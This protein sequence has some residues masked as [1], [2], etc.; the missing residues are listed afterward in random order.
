MC[1]AGSIGTEVIDGDGP[2]PP[3]KI[4]TG[5]WSVALASTTSIWLR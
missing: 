4:G 2:M 3:E 1:G 5:M